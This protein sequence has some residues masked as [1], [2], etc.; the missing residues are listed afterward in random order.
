MEQ[1]HLFV[2]T[3]T[4][5]QIKCI[6]FSILR[7]F[8]DLLSD[9]DKLFF[10]FRVHVE[11]LIVI[12]YSLH[13]IRHKSTWTSFLVYRQKRLSNL[14][15]LLFSTYNSFFNKKKQTWPP[16][17]VNILQTVFGKASY[18]AKKKT[19]NIPWKIGHGW[20]SNKENLQKLCNRW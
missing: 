17:A 8:R 5:F 13:F 7:F 1:W 20:I 11:R 2:I 19:T 6:W 12:S 18:L 16:S 3:L 14:Q 4:P 10:C 9:F 15:Q